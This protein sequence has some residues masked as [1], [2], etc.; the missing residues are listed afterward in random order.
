M[1]DRHWNKPVCV[2]MGGLGK[3]RNVTSTR[4][5]AECLLDRWP[6]GKSTGPGHRIAREACVTVLAGEDPPAIARTAFIIAAQEAG[7]FVKNGR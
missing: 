3:L 6:A 1:D 5:A 2:T 7:I 4:E